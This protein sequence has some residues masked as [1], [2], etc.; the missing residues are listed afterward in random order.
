[1]TDDH[2]PRVFEN[3]ALR[4]MLVIE[5][6]SYKRLEKTAYWGASWFA[7]LSRYFGDQIK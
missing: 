7:F 4:K 1:L 5:G 3:R 6:W 2:R